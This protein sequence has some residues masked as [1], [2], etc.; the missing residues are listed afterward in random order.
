M[1]AAMATRARRPVPTA[2]YLESGSRRVFA[3]ALDWPGWC[4]SGKDEKQALEALAAA[5]PRYALVAAEADVPFPVRD[6][7]GFDVVE[8]LAGSA[9]TDFG[10]PGEVAA[11]DT[12]PLT[13]KGAGRLA[14]LVAGSGSSTTAS[15][16]PATACCW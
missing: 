13:R 11:S 6:G 8:R 14:T 4:R 5:A 1:L 12:E 16:I 2:V 3:C 15:P 9:T 7:G 10:A